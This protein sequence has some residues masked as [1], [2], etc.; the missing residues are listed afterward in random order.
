[1]SGR[2]LI[3]EPIA[4]TG[5]EQLRHAVDVEVRLKPTHAELMGMIGRFDGLIVRSSTQV[6]AEVLVAAERLVVVGRAGT[7]VDN[8]DL[9]AAT[10]R[11]VMVVNA[12][13]SNT[14]AVA[15]HTVALMLSLARHIPQA[16]ASAH[17]G[18]WEKPSF[19]GTELRGKTMGL[20][21]LGRVGRAVAQRIQAFEVQ[22]LA[23]DPF[24]SPEVSRRFG[25]RIVSLEELL[26]GSDYVSLHAPATER[27]RGMISSNEI[28]LMKPSAYL[29]NC[30][31]GD[32]L[33]QEA[34]L[35]AVC[36]GRL[37]GAALD[38]FPE[39]PRIDPALCENAQ[40]LL[41]PHLGASTEEAQSSASLEVAQQVIDVLAGRPPSHPVN[42]TAISYD[43]LEQIRPY[44]DLATRMGRFYAQF[45]EE[46]L[47]Q[48]EITYAGDLVELNTELITAGLLR[49]LFARSGTSPVNLVNARLIAEERGL[50]IREVRTSQAE[51][52]AGLLTLS[53]TT[54]IGQHL[55]KGTIIRAEPHIV[56]VEQYAVD[57]VPSGYLLV[58]EHLDQPGIVGRIGTILG[59]EQVNISFV[60][61]GRATEGGTAIMVLGV[62]EPL[63]HAVLASV[64]SLSSIRS[65]HLIGLE[66]L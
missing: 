59:D 17:A 13:T 57:F 24:V 35:E 37:A 2:V 23:Y 32:L 52:F 14:V 38:V 61:L 45:S 50:V 62:D 11:G 44:L 20:I 26:A 46:S 21:G 66:S 28:A 56:Q 53:A 29:I 19:M 51:D 39:E 49:G 48:L 15:E 63:S 58:D 65:A 34:L 22:I 36:A 40:L 12:P 1:M 9:D 5:L 33:D 16:N 25:A 27:T 8:I 64:Q 55:L 18:M 7:G 30:A 41:T 43:A 31:R 4:E 42:V 54:A 6:D 3:T 47:I 60:Q 10:H